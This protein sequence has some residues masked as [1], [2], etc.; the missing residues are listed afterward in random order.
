[1]LLITP[2]TAFSEKNIVHKKLVEEILK[3]F[4]KKE[5]KYDKL[6][7]EI[8]TKNQLNISYPINSEQLDK[9]NQEQM[10]QILKSLRSPLAEVD[11]YTWAI[12]LFDQS[13][14]AYNKFQKLKQFNSLSSD[15]SEELSVSPNFYNDV[16]DSL[17]IAVFISIQRI[18]EKTEDSSSISIRKFI[19]KCRDNL[20]IFPQYSQ[21]YFYDGF[22]DNRP[23]TWE[24][25]KNDLTFLKDKFPKFYKFFDHTLERVDITPSIL[26]ELFEWKF[27]KFEDNDKLKNL[28]TQRDKIF[29][30]NDKKAMNNFDKIT[31]DNP[32]SYQDLDDFIQFSLN[33]SHMILLMLTNISKAF[34]PRKHDDWE[35]T[36]KYVRK[37]ME[38]EKSV[39]QKERERLENLLKENFSNAT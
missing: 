16:R 14:A 4:S 23:W 30:H 27:K 5:D 31:S 12:T 26:I 35:D 20:R 13:R 6:L 39:L 28:Y 19:K 2:N 32:L 9:L 8:N 18:Y 22:I 24:V 33:F 25:S 21:T 7:F 1:M 15:Y 10:I 17:L 3:I 11:I 38:K 29:V 37:G 36:L 34:E